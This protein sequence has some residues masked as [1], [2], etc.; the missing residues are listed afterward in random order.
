MA[1]KSRGVSSPT[2]H[3]RFNTDKTSTG[4]TA[5]ERNRYRCKSRRE[6]AEPCSLTYRFTSTLV[7]KYA[8]RVCL[9]A[10]LALVGSSWTD[11]AAEPAWASIPEGLCV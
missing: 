2:L 5:E 11:G 6:T 1:K 8:Q 7:S 4:A 3:R 10:C 9:T